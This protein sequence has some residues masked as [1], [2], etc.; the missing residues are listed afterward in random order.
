[1]KIKKLI[2]Q[3]TVTEEDDLR[4]IATRLIYN[5]LNSSHSTHVVEVYAIEEGEEDGK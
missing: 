3:E 2:H 5:I 1:M 4:A